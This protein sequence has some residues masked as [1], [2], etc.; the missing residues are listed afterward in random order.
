MPSLFLRKKAN[1]CLFESLCN[2]LMDDSCRLTRESL[3]MH[4]PFLDFF[5]S[6]ILCYP[7]CM[8]L[9]MSKEN[10]CFIMKHVYKRESV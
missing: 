7:V 4:G 1:S 5:V 9:Q 3:I 2:F 8:S 6:F 10:R